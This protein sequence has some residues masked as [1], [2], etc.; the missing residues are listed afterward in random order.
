M[1]RSTF[2]AFKP[3][4]RNGRALREGVDG[5][6]AFRAQGDK[7]RAHL[8]FLVR[9]SR[10][11][12]GLKGTLL[13]LIFIRSFSVL[14]ITESRRFRRVL[15]SATRVRRMLPKGFPFGKRIRMGK[16]FLSVGERKLRAESIVKM[17]DTCQTMR[18]LLEHCLCEGNG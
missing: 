4:G 15:L 14:P 8:F 16:Y 3:P 18:F 6:R 10:L 7:R 13:S 1:A 9:A 11:R 5:E 17:L 2:D 12:V